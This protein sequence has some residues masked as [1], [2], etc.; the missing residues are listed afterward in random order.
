[1][2]CHRS[3]TQLPDIIDTF[4]VE[5]AAQTW[6]SITCIV[7][8]PMPCKGGKIVV[9]SNHWGLNA[10]RNDFGTVYLP[11]EEHTMLPYKWFIREVFHKF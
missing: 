4:F 10:A 5:M 3:I 6:W 2:Q 11:F 1:M 8:G 7:G 9:A